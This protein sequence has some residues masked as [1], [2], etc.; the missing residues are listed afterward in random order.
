MSRLHRGCCKAS[1]DERPCFFVLCRAK[2]SK[3]LFFR[4]GPPFDGFENLMNCG[5]EITSCGS[6]DR[7]DLLR[8]D[9]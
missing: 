5:S 1:L 2:R 6:L 8:G 9:L 7:K 3:H 4:F